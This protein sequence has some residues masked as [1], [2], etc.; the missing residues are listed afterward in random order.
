MSQQD[1]D[2]CNEP[3][4]HSMY[5]RLDAELVDSPDMYA[6]MVASVELMEVAGRVPSP[7]PLEYDPMLEMR[8]PSEQKDK[9]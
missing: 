9:A 8:D 4:A 7:P 6:R 5:R 3:A 1:A 2:Q